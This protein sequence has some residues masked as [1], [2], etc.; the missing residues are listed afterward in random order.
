GLGHRPLTA[1]TGIRIPLGLPFF[2][3]LSVAG[4]LVFLFGYGEGHG[5]TNDEFWEETWGNFGDGSKSSLCQKMSKGTFRTV[6]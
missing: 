5:D 2:G 3:E 6:P 4:L 1:K